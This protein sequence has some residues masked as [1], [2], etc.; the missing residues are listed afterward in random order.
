MIQRHARVGTN[1]GACPRSGMPN[2]MRP[3]MSSASPA[4][5]RHLHRQLR[6]VKPAHVLAAPARRGVLPPV[7]A[8]N[9]TGSIFSRT[10]KVGGA[11]ANVVVYGE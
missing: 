10:L 6:H 3:R 7:Q 8:Q 1:V 9:G 2:V 5:H 11:G 4:S